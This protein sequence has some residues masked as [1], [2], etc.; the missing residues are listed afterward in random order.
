MCGMPAQIA[1][2]ILFLTMFVLMISDRIERHIVTLGCGL[3]TLAVVFGL[4][5]GSPAAITRKKS[6]PI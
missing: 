6:Y 2:V 4:C 3:L 5:M 1:A